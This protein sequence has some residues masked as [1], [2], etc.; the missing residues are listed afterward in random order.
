MACIRN[1]EEFGLEV[2]ELA[3]NELAGI[4]DGVDLFRSPPQ[5]IAHRNRKRATIDG[6]T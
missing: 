6:I 4:H 3:R 5:R 2:L 1:L